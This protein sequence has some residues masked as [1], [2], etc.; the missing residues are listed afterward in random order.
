MIAS[1]EYARLTEVWIAFAGGEIDFPQAL[2]SAVSPGVLAHLDAG[3]VDT[4]AEV[5][6]GYRNDGRALV[7]VHMYRL[8]LVALGATPVSAWRTETLR[9]G[10]TSAI[11]AAKTSLSESPDGVL[12]TW[13]LSLA[14]AELADATD[15]AVIG[16][17]SFQSGAL[18]LDPYIA[19]RVVT[20]RSDYEEGIRL[21]LIR[22]Q[23]NAN[24]RLAEVA[25]AAQMPEPA[26]ALAAAEEWFR[27]AIAQQTGSDRGLGIKAL[28]QTILAR[29]V[30]YAVSFAAPEVDE[31]V[32][33]ALTLLPPRT[34]GV[35]YAAVIEMGQRLGRPSDLTMLAPLLTPPFVEIVR[36][37][38]LGDAREL[39]IEIVGSL[40][41]IDPLRA[42]TLFVEARPLVTFPVAATQSDYLML[43]L[44]TMLPATTAV[45]RDHLNASSD[46]DA[47]RAWLDAQAAAGETPLA[48][49]Y[50][51]LAF[52][53]MHRSQE[54]AGLTAIAALRERFPAF[55]DEHEAA[56]D[57][58]EVK[59]IDGWAVDARKAGAYA[60]A[61]T[62][63]GA[64][65]T[66]AL[67]AGLIEEAFSELSFLHEVVMQYRT[68]DTFDAAAHVFC[69]AGL[70]LQAAAGDRALWSIVTLAEATLF[71]VLQL[72]DAA[73][74]ATVLVP[75]ARRLRARVFASELSVGA[76]YD[77][78]ADPNA[79]AQLA[80]II[81]TALE[82]GGDLLGNPGVDI[83]ED[84]LL[85]TY[86]RRFD[87]RAGAAPDERLANL[88][89]RFDAYVD[90]RLLPPAAAQMQR[91]TSSDLQAR[92]DPDTVVVDLYINDI[93]QFGAIAIALLST[94]EQT[95]LIRNPNM[96]ANPIADHVATLR[97]TVVR[98][99]DGDVVDYDAQQQ[100]IADA[101]TILGAPLL[102]H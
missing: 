43:E 66:R 75:F 71:F 29:A 34:H 7:A 39:V 23:Q 38:Q 72:G 10:R 52:G 20:D 28:L 51:M 31:L 26:D 63:F 53:A 42:V 21:W 95:T 81:A 40:Q 86:I 37:Q 91:V 82:A 5:A 15:A 65:I 61:V 69:D 60:D 9:K 45:V 96:P 18:Y 35:A 50:V 99:A 94:N 36:T 85:G 100:L 67:Q 55:A 32:N 92:I 6:L 77:A 41:R 98:Y 19:G 83:D 16:E 27:R 58:L 101:E 48:C 2:R 64:A 102:K 62:R 17:F 87:T 1:P 56:L 22:F 54:P 78:A 14:Q 47:G 46:I 24:D 30:L 8:L 13:A 33:D 3:E 25:A 93:A 90:D 74:A 97:S 73:S 12:F 88:Q 59:L 4:F 84:T 68:A 44:L 76:R 49:A 70:A 80:R 89:H 11:A 79:V 57:L